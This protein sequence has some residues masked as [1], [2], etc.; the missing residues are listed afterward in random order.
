M[1]DAVVNRTDNLAG[2]IDRMGRMA[3]G[4]QYAEGL[5][6]AQWESLRFLAAANNRSRTPSALAAY[7]G[8]TKG[9][10]SQ[11]VI[12]LE[13][14]GLLRRRRGTGDRRVI[15]LE[16]TPDGTALL[17][18][19]PLLSLDCALAELPEDVSQSLVDGL[20]RLKDELAER[21][22][23]KSFGVCAEC[24]HFLGPDGAAPARCGKSRTTL[25]GEEFH[26]ICIEFQTCTAPGA[27]E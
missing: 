23:W 6:P 15:T 13:G 21:H 10:A 22:G 4:L 9:T 25:E 11:T 17:D 7:L 26:R 20:A 2:L 1:T 24:G 27:A 5:N 3:R 16:L 8:S 19:D 12:A 18:R 14:K